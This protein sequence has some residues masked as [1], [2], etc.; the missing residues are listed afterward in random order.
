M[1]SMRC[2][3]VVDRDQPGRQRRHGH[4]RHA[5]AGGDQRDGKTALRI[6]P[7]GHAGHHRREDGGGRRTDQQT[8]E[9]LKRDQ[10]FRPAGERQARRQ[11]DRPREHHR[12]RTEPVGEV[13]PDHAGR[14]HG[15]ETDRHRRGD[16]GDGPAG[17]L[18]HRP[19][20]DR[21]R[22][23]GA[24][25]DAAQQ[26]ARRNDQPTA[27]CFLLLVFRTPLLM[28]SD[29]GLHDL[30]DAFLYANRYAILGSSPRTCSAR[31]RY[32]NAISLAAASSQP[33]E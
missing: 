6:E 26:A 10:R 32:R 21:Q 18:R 19:Q 29:A 2:S 7:A 12:A 1:I 24:D 23:H 14:R 9:K 20:E 11:H 8:E 30:F 15:E 31:K 5:H 25:C 16:A 3:P 17:L 33:M 28:E 22:E 27:A 4:R 13:A